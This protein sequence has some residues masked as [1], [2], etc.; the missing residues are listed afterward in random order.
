VSDRAD[1]IAA[2]GREGR[3]AE[4]GAVNPYAGDGA[5]ALS[6]DLGYRAMLAEKMQNSTAARLYAKRDNSN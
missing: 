1:R 4:P 6:W 5:V 2:A 3:A